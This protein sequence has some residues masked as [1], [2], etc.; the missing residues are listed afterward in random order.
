L[1]VYYNMS[2]V[3]INT[4]QY[5]ALVK[6]MSPRERFVAKS[7]ISRFM[8][9][10]EGRMPNFIELKSAISDL[11]NSDQ[12]GIDYNTFYNEV[13]GMFKQAIPTITDAEL[14]QRVRFVDK[15][16]LMRLRNDKEVLTSFI[17]GVVYIARDL[18]ALRGEDRAKDDVRHEIF[19]VIFNNFLSDDEQQKMIET[20]KR[21]KPQYSSIMD[22]EEIEE[23]MAD[24]WENYKESPKKTIPILV[25]DFFLDILKFLGFINSEYNNIQKLFDDVV[26]GKFTRNYLR[27]SLVTRDKT[28]LSKYTE[29]STDPDL[30]LQAKAFVLN[31]MNELMNP[32]DNKQLTEV[33]NGNLF[34]NQNYQSPLFQNNKD[35]FKLGLTKNDA[36]KQ[37]QKR[38]KA[39]K[40]SKTV[41]PQLSK[42]IN[43]LSKNFILKDL[44]D[45]LQPYSTAKINSDGELVLEGHEEEDPTEEL[46]ETGEDINSLEIGSKELINPVTKISEVVKD[47][48]SNITYETSPGNFVSIDPGAG[49]ISLLNL[50]GSMYGNNSVED[51]LTS[52]KTA[53]NDTVKGNQTKAVYNKLRDLHESLQASNRIVLSIKGV[54]AQDLTNL[55]NSLDQSDI[56]HETFKDTMTIIVPE[57]MKIENKGTNNVD[58]K[59]VFTFNRFKDGQ[60]SYRFVQR[61]NESNKTYIENVSRQTGIPSFVISKLFKYNEQRN[62]LAEL[63]KVAGSL[64]K[65]SPKFVKVQTSRISVDGFNQQITTYAFINK[66]NEYKSSGSLASVIRDR[67]DIQ[68]LRQEILASVA[69]Y[70]TLKDKGSRIELR[71]LLQDVIVNKLNA[72]SVSDFQRV[73]EKD[74]TNLLNSLDRIVTFT[75]DLATNKNSEEFDTSDQYL[76]HTS[77]FANLL[78]RYTFEK[79]NPTSFSVSTS[80]KQKWENVMKNTSFM[81]FDN[82]KN[83]A[84]GVIKANKLLPYL[85]NSFNNYLRYNP[86]FDHNYNTGEVGVNETLLKTSDEDFYSDHQETYFENRNSN[87]D[88]PPVPFSKES[89]RDWINRNFLAMFQLPI[90]ETQT[91]SRKSERAGLSYYQQKFQ[92]ESAPNVSVIK[93]GVHSAESVQNSIAMMI[94]QEA[95]MNHLSGGSIRGNIVKNNKKSLL[96][97]LEGRSYFIEN[98]VNIFFNE[99]GEL[100]PEFGRVVNGKIHLNRANTRLNALVESVLNNLDSSLDEFVDLTLTEKATLDGSQIA[101]M[102][103][104]I[105][106]SYLNKYK[107]TDAEKIVLKGISVDAKTDIEAF[108]SDINYQDRKTVLKKA[109]SSYY[110]N[111]FVNGFFMNQLSSGSTQNYKNPL[112]EIKRQAGVNAMNDTGLIDNKHGMKNSYKNVVISAANNFYGQ[113][114]RFAEIPL[115]KRFFSNKVQE[116]GDAQSWDIP[117]FKTMLR[118]SFGKSVDIGVITKDVHFEINKDGNVDYR[119]TSSAELTN[120]LVQKNKTLRD[121][122]F[123]MTFAPY[124]K[125]LQDDEREV[126]TNRVNYLYNKMIDNANKNN[127]FDGLLD[128]LD[129]Y[130]EYQD[131]LQ[132]IQDKNLMIHKA[133]FESAIKGSKPIKMS[134]F[135][136][137]NE[138]GTFDFTLEDDSVLELNSAYTGIQQAI[139][140]KYIDSFISHFTQLTYLIGLN[141]TETSIKNNKII[142]RTLSRFAKAGVFDSL[143]DYKMAY[144][145]EGIMKANLR[146]KKEFI[147]DLVKKLDLPGNER[148]VSLLNTP[149]ISMN[150]PLFSEKLMQTFF[151]SFSKKTVA[152][153]HPGGSFVL[154]SEFGFEANRILSQ[155]S[156]RIPEL[157]TDN[158][159]NIL[160]AECYLPE[161]YSDQIKAGDMIYYNSEQYNKMFGFRIP[162]SDLHSSVPLRIIGYYP[163]SMQDNV[164]VIPSAVTALHGSDFDVDKLFVVRYGV[165]GQNDEDV[166]PKAVPTNETENVKK[167]YKTRFQTNNSVVAQKGIKYGYIAPDAEYNSQNNLS[168]FGPNDRHTPIIGLDGILIDEKEKTEKKIIQ[169]EQ[170][171]TESDKR[172]AENKFQK[173]EKQKARRALMAEVDSFTKHLK[174]LRSIQKG[175][176]SNTILDAVLDN[177][178]YSGE[179]ASDIL[180]GITFDPVKGYEDNSE[181]SEL[182]RVFSDINRAAGKDDV[183]REKPTLYKSTQEAEQENPELYRKKKDILE[184]NLGVDTTTERGQRDLLALINQDAEDNWISD[185]D[186]FIKRQSPTVNNINKVEQ[187]VRIHKDTYMAAGLVGLIANFSKGL[188][189]AFHGITDNNNHI[190]LDIPENQMIELD[191]IRIDK[192]T[193]S[194]KDNVKNQE[195]RSLV[196]NAAI[197]H[198]KEQILNVL[199]VGNKT[200]KMFLAA[201]S[202]DLTLHQSSMIMLQPV[203][204]EL[205]SSNATTVAATLKKMQLAITEKLKEIGN[206]LNQTEVDELKVTTKDLEKHIQTDFNT[207][208]SDSNSTNYRKNLVL[209][210]KVI[211][212]LNTL[213]QIG[214]EISEISQTLS[215]IQG[216]PYS[217]ENAYDKIKSLNKFIDIEKFFEKLKYQEKSEYTEPGF[218][219]DLKSDKNILSNVNLANNENILAALEAIKAQI[220]VSSEM[221]TENSVQAQFLVNNMIKAI[222]NNSDPSTMF[223][224][225]YDQNLNFNTV[226]DMPIQEKY[227]KGK[228]TFNM[229]KMISRNI[230]NYLTSGLNIAYN[231][232][233]HLFSLSISNQKLLTIRDK[234]DQQFTLG[235]VRSYIESFLM[236]EKYFYD[237]SRNYNG[238]DFVIS[239]INPEWRLKPLGL[240]KSQNPN[241]KFLKGIGIDTNFR[242]KVRIMTFNGSLVNTAENLA[243][244][245][246]AVN[247]LNN[248]S[249][250]YVRL[251]KKGKWEDVPSSL[252]PVTSEMNEITFN[253]LKASLYIDKFKFGMSKATNVIPPIY[254]QKMFQ[255]LETLVK[256]LIYYQK[257]ETG[258]KYYKDFRDLDN[259]GNT[260][261]ALSDL[262]ENLFVNTI[263]SIPTVLPNL[264]NIIPNK[265]GWKHVNRQAGILYNGNIYDM[266]LDANILD[267][268]TQGDDTKA[269][270]TIESSEILTEE[271]TNQEVDQDLSESQAE[272]DLFEKF[273]KNPSFIVDESPKKPG[274]Y[275]IYMKIGATGS[276]EGNDLKYYYKKIGRVNGKLTNNSFDLNLLLNHYQIKDYFNPKRLAI[277]TKDV[278]FSE[279][280][281]SLHNVTISTFITNAYDDVRTEAQNKQKIEET[282]NQQIAYLQTLPEN[283]NKSV[284]QI[285]GEVRSKLNVENVLNQINEISLF[286]SRNMDRIG[287]KHFKILSRTIS[288]DRR[289]VSFELEALP[290]DQQITY[291]KFDAPLEVLKTVKKAGLSR[292]EKIE[293]INSIPGTKT[294]TTAQADQ[295]TD[296]QIDV[297]FDR[298]TEIDEAKEINK[299]LKDKSCK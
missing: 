152:P 255:S 62:Q 57:T 163:S 84:N 37:L 85:Q 259:Q 136:K 93:M 234:E 181:Y 172:P 261:S 48:L 24:E 199:N 286:D 205:N 232:D 287:L 66:V 282:I 120:E 52:L 138:T 128:N 122:R 38:I 260:R 61:D 22:K 69:R 72:I 20:F 91:A 115:L 271:N 246:Q 247:E 27:D 127:E 177:I 189:Y 83:F 99:N 204:K 132:D 190:S 2:C 8:T 46:L 202:T 74:V 13:R 140:H 162:S 207:M 141:R 264:R 130:M 96:P 194:N 49:F 80:N 34:L 44:F 101:I 39:L 275:E 262:K 87:Y 167:E 67:L 110:L 148:I 161:M 54:S 30:F 147:K 119:K 71:A 290:Q 25:R 244:V 213:N 58:N 248:L 45:Y 231:D 126:M 241:N 266:Y 90:N 29:F 157:V 4:P 134:Q 274:T 1:N 184:N 112:D 298:A 149:K 169:L 109:L 153:K 210:Y 5:K 230:F 43:V 21:W 28:I 235:T 236:R 201:I 81:I 215:I 70:R 63:T 113:S 193:L 105:A 106:S 102:Y 64:R 206:P 19:H 251:N 164:V 117:E 143:F 151:N 137:N 121:L 6:G 142:T 214:N 107:L 294:I 198:V 31:N 226:R 252:H 280:R 36:L 254:F 243:E 114:H 267:K 41:D 186:E 144:S 86:L 249:N 170:E 268:Q 284:A 175:L 11:Y 133:S 218:K 209:Q 68:E 7:V 82:L 60:Q 95:Y 146:S 145:D 23:A 200:A 88:K 129:E 240:I 216:L 131:I 258:N 263:F 222:S 100:N 118:K 154:Q 53:Y 12:G 35:I 156:M 297:E 42:V 78:Q 187:H 180:F 89:P 296:S 269:E 220:D 219:N 76:R 158:D 176:Y 65:L 155:N 224:G 233:N 228:N 183:V 32:E 225:E 173:S 212:Q 229:F 283:A 98:G 292:Q 55:R 299:V 3:N 211:Q 281:V 174:T 196:L 291:N 279:N 17:E 223:T 277:P 265:N 40:D 75:P 14:D 272:T 285:R 15:L 278:D 188:A 239:Q 171:M 104:K 203:A 289:S 221:F 16:E 77:N 125:S 273:R 139:R 197:D 208:M 238:D 135:I 79:N 116:V 270:T 26:N 123:A 92:P 237:S 59:V 182:A 124:L 103:D 33:N 159:G 250:I 253:I 97:G 185:R 195:L 179:N 166:D 293:Y 242:D 245:E 73:S 111:S 288:Q 50:L 150:N 191:G 108:T 295:M 9:E 18:P 94:V 178:S 276:K 192:L 51:N 257:S 10:N 217:L 47:F 256:D 165:F 227:L 56:Q 168:S 160:Y